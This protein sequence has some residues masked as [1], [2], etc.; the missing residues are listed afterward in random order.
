MSAMAQARSTSQS[1][2]IIPQQGLDTPSATGAGGGEFGPGLDPLMAL[3]LQGVVG[4]EALAALMRA[5]SGADPGA[6]FD[7]AAGGKKESLPNQSKLEGALG[8]DLSGL[9]VVRGPEAEAALTGLNARSALKGDVILLG[10]GATDEDVAH[11]AIHYEQGQRNGGGNKDVD[12]GKA[13]PAEAEAHEGAK[14][15]AAG[16]P[17]DVQE[18]AGAEVNR[19]GLGDLWDGAKDLGNKA[20]E[21]AKDLGAGAL[22][23]GKAAVNKVADV[24]TAA[25]KGIWNTGK[26]AVTGVVDTA[27]A[28]GKG[29]LNVGG[30]L[31]SGAW[32][33]AASLGSGALGA[34][35]ELLSGLGAAGGSLWGGVTDAAKNFGDWGAMGE[36]LWGG[37]KGAGSAL[38][39]GVQGA[40]G[41]LVGGVTDAAGAAWDGLKNAGGSLKEGA[42]NT[43]DEG[44]GA[45]TSTVGNAAAGFINTLDAGIGL[46]WIDNWIQNGSAEAVTE[47]SDSRYYSTA[48]LNTTDNKY[49]AGTQIPQNTTEF[50]QQFSGLGI[51]LTDEAW[52]RQNAIDGGKL[53]RLHDTTLLGTLSDAGVLDQ[54][55]QSGDISAEDAQQ[56]FSAMEP[57]ALAELVRTVDGAGATQDFFAAMDSKTWTTFQEG[58]LDS[59]I[60]MA[61]ADPEK[62]AFFLD[63][64]P[65]ELDIKP[66]I[67]ELTGD[68]APNDFRAG[69]VTSMMRE[70]SVRASELLREQGKETYG[71]VVPYAN[72]AENIVRNQGSPVDGTEHLSRYLGQLDARTTTMASGYSQSGAAVLDYANQHGGTQGLD[73]VNAI[74]PMGGADRQGGD[75]VWAGTVRANEQDP[76]VQVTSFMNHADP[77]KYIHTADGN[78]AFH[79]ALAN[80]AMPE[81]IFGVDTKK[82]DGELH[83]GF[84]DESNRDPQ[85][86]SNGYPMDMAVNYIGD[87]LNGE[88]TNKD[89]GR[90][91]DWT[92]D[93]RKG[94]R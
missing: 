87:M 41:S 36:S 35:E 62:A 88:Y 89:Y 60:A 43:L 4:N 75:G 54:L 59:Y 70:G 58:I 79:A 5:E 76:G 24:G 94:D 42:L 74:A 21:G 53:K 46:G 14:R 80:F 27:A 84:P 31:L 17:V 61:N 23:L 33:A 77:A 56:D 37:A 18:A 10:G 7:Q 39:G 22:D 81:S 72:T 25:A 6:L 92:P 9:K 93:R 49:A 1:A 50:T 71:L 2:G 32:N 29:L 11:E 67:L 55:V 8:G 48:P 68:E 51:P 57:E 45:L 44:W 15:A 83:A 52:A 85:H 82:G 34:G 13:D 91:G 38:W 40:G 63:V 90:I 64:L 78:A 47:D 30:D 69:A 20:L 66:S 86:G 19:W 28:A 26:A 16:E 12:G 73:Y 3:R 65:T